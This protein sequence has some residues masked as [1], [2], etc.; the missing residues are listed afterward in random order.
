MGKAR[1]SHRLIGCLTFAKAHI[2][3]DAQERATRWFR[4]NNEMW[5]NRSQPGTEV[6]DEAQERITHKLLVT[7][8]VLLKPLAVVV[9]F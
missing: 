3:V 2:S 9:T 4:I 7:P 5:A 8:L 6:L 1:R